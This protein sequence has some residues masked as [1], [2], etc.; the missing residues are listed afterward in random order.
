MALPT[1]D[2]FFD[3]AGTPD[4]VSLTPFS[5]IRWAATNEEHVF[6]APDTKAWIMN[7]FQAAPTGVPT[8]FAT[9]AL[10]LALFP[11][12]PNP[13]T[14]RVALSFLLGSDAPVTLDIFDAAGRRADRL[15]DGGMLPAGRHVLHWSPKAGGVYFYRVNAAG[16]SA[17]GRI[18]A[19]LR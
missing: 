8:A 16:E 10:A 2:L 18:T 17:A 1:N 4:V 19:L 11:A 13:F 12:F 15:L 3:V 7:E 5:A 6:I 14:D 9:Q